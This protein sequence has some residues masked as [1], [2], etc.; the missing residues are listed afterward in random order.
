MWGVFWHRV[1]VPLMNMDTWALHHSLSGVTSVQEVAQV[2]VDG[3]FHGI[4]AGVLST[5]T[6]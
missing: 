2:L 3:V 6:L 1:T 4:Y 5:D